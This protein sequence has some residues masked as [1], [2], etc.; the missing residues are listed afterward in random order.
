MFVIMYTG[1][2]GEQRYGQTYVFDTNASGDSKKLYEAAKAAQPPV[3]LIIYRGGPYY[4][5]TAWARVEKLTQIA[6]KRGALPG[7]KLDLEWHEFPTPLN[8]KVNAA[9]LMQ[10]IAWL[11]NGLGKAFNWRSIRLITVPEFETII[12]AARGDQSQVPLNDA[13]YLRLNQVGGGPLKLNEILTDIMEDELV[14]G[15]ASLTDLSSAMVND[16]A[17]RFSRLGQDKWTI[18]PTPPEPWLPDEWDRL[19]SYVEF[20][21]S[22][23]AAKNYSATELYQ[24]ATTQF[25]AAFNPNSTPSGLVEDLLQLRLMKTVQSSVTVDDG[26]LYMLQDYL[27]SAN[28]SNMDTLVKLSALALLQ[29]TENGH[30]L[31]ALTLMP[32]L[33]AGLENPQPIEEFTVGFEP[34][35]RKLLDWY[36]EAG[37]VTVA[38][39]IWE[40]KPGAL[41][42]LE[43]LPGDPVNY[44]YN[45]F[46]QALLAEVS[47]TLPPAFPPVDGPLPIVPD[48]DDKLKQLGQK[49]LIDDNVVRRVYRS[50]IAGR[51]VVLSGPPGTGKT[52]LA[53]LLPELLWREE[54]SDSWQL[55]YDLSEPPAGATPQSR[56][57][58]FPDVV[59]ANENWGVRDVIGGIGP[60]LGDTGTINYEIQYGH[61]T[62]VLLQN[63]AG[64]NAPQ[65]LRQL[66]FGLTREAIIINSKPYRGVWLLIDEFTRAP[67][68]AAFG[69]LLTTLSGGNHAFL[70]VPTAD[71]SEVQIPLPPDFRIIATLNSFDRHFLNQMSEALKRRF[72]FIDVFPPN[73]ADSEYE[74]GIAVKQALERLHGNGYQQQIIIDDTKRANE[75]EPETY[76]WQGNLT[77]SPAQVGG[78]WRYIVSFAQPDNLAKQA[79]ESFWRIFEAIRVFRQLGTAQ[80]TAVYTNLFTGVLTGMNW[81]TSLDAALANSLADQLQVL[82]R[83]EQHILAAL[84]EYAG[85]AEGFLKQFKEIISKMPSGRRPGFLQMLREAEKLRNRNVATIQIDEGAEKTLG[86]NEI[87]RVFAIER[88][89]ALPESNGIFLRRLYNLLSER[90]L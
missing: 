50:L 79:L 28:S 43:D 59:T 25:A 9:T 5:F 23:E 42:G 63:Y 15:P 58:Y 18:T 36:A 69:S 16:P 70:A 31:P 65:K 37:L 57:G 8:L 89:L 86:L 35:G 10:E 38:D 49:L 12:Q 76:A 78:L 75:S 56:A 21:S 64:E 74:Q 54:M 3:H 60:R 2:S 51:H 7:L 45:G 20:V 11:K 22:L 29:P 52:A 84:V 62:R 67:V 32:R 46:L 17:K 82:N 85:D 71:G 19:T 39:D 61:L 14:A 77:V 34:D 13:A 66:E 27:A 55:R 48:L 47:G 73:P 88:P 41:V 83:D 24:V 68:D 1:K 81:Q 80:V 33:Q 6:P 44:F 90:G 53:S 40:T 30:A 4:S 87:K 72:D 26:E